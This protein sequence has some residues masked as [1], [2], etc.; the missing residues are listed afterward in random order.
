VR[1]FLSLSF[2]GTHYC[3]WQRQP[4]LSTVQGVVE[5]VLSEILHSPVQTMG[6]GRTDAGVHARNFIMHFDTE[7]SLPD[8][9]LKRINHMLP[10]DIAAHELYIP[11]VDT[12]HARYHALWRSYTYSWH[13]Q[14]DPFIQLYSHQVTL[15][16]QQEKLLTCAEFITGL[17]DFKTFSKS[18]MSVKTSAC[19]VDE[20]RWE[21]GE[22]QWLFHIRSSR[23]L[24]GMVRLLIGSMFEVS[25]GRMTIGY[26]RELIEFPGI[27]PPG[28][29]APAHGLTF[30]G[31]AYPEGSLKVIER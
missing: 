29:S 18:G 3:G 31:T 30:T 27:K 16:L 2:T 7:K 23:F 10:D 13:F 6:T 15:P 17:H 24:R 26:F 22:H 21:F 5:S 9:F 25:R 20:A 12:L 28:K 1:Y 14:K 8:S 4:G 11:E 19:K